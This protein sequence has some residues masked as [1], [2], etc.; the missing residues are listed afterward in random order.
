MKIKK[1]LVGFMG[2]LLLLVGCT[3]KIPEGKIKD[4]VEKIENLNAM[5]KQKNNSSY[6]IL[7]FGVEYPQVK[8]KAALSKVNL[9]IALCMKKIFG[10]YGYCS[11]LSKGH[12]V[13]AMPEIP[14]AKMQQ[15]IKIQLAHIIR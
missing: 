9:A 7:S 11:G 8:T 2:A 12:F 1:H 3:P 6:G 13:V 14:E 4:F 15:L 5:Q 10:Y